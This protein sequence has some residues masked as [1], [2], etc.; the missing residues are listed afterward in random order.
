MIQYT[1]VRSRRRTIAI[2]ITKMATV[3]VRAPQKMSK[4]AIER[5]ISS[6]QKW[7]EAHL[8]KR[9]LLNDKKSAFSLNYGDAV[10]LCGKQYTIIC[11]AV[12]RGWFDGGNFILPPG[13]SSDGI[14][15]AIIQ[16]YK[17][18]AKSIFN[19]RISF[20]SRQLNVVPSAVRVTSAKTR[21]GSC[22]GKNSL[23][24]SWR[25]V[26]ADDKIIDYVVIHELAHI[27]EHNHSIRFWKIVENMLPDYKSRQKELKAFQERLSAQDWDVGQR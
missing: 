2:H 13:L 15:N 19:N 5:F 18:L 25:L 14:K 8:A 7:I 11:N 21:W 23:N 1:L 9:K 22:S 10:A 4:T 27:K 24:F 6:K 12:R 3:E 20:Y 16:I 17:S 26:L